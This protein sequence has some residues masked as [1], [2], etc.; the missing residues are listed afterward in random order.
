MEDN[1]NTICSKLNAIQVSLIAPKGQFNSFGKY[2]YRNCEDILNA[3]KPHLKKQ[4]CVVLLSDKPKMIGERYYIEA[5]ASIIDCENGQTISVNA[6]ARESSD[7]KGMDDSQLTG[8]T[9][10]Y[11]RKYALN[12]LFAI[13]DTKDADSSEH[14]DPKSVSANAKYDV[15]VPQNTLE[16]ISAEQ[17][18]QVRAELDRTGIAESTVLTTLNIPSI[19]KMKLGSFSA[20]MNKFKNTATKKVED[21]NE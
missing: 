19:E 5:T 11:A 9:S 12:G 20:V 15:P 7:K 2:K 16:T 1:K 18:N 10:S 3:L 21:K 17:I 13:D 14:Q 6:L 4:K 8:S